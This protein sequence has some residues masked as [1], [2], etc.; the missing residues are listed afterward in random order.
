MRQA[1]IRVNAA[2]GEAVYHGMSRTGNEE[3]LLDDAAKEVW[4]KQLW[5]IAD[6]GGV[7]IITYAMRS[8]P[9][10]VLLRVPRKLNNP[11]SEL[12]RRYAV[13]Y[14]Q[15]TKYQTAVLPVIESQLAPDGPDAVAWRDKQQA[16]RGDVSQ[17]M[18]LGKP[19]FSV[20]CNRSH[21]R[22]GTLWSERFKSVLVAAKAGTMR[23]MAAYIDRNA[24][25]AGLVCDPPDYRFCGYGEAVAWS[26]AF[27]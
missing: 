11:D 23:T 15:P 18:K 20:W 5:R 21:Q 19:R 24:V 9:F 27:Y 17:F 2:E 8:N 13:L 16:M 4:R 26:L 3:R 12:L 1:R 10:H 7:Q 22:Y 14:P 6:H 25:R